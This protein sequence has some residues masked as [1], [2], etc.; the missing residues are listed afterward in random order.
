MKILYIHQ[1]FRLPNQD[2]GHRSYYIAQALQNAGFEVEIIT[3]KNKEDD[4]ENNKNQ[5]KKINV[6]GLTIHYLPIEYHQS[7]GFWGRIKAFRNF[8]WEAYKMALQIHDTKKI[9]LVYATSTPLTVGISAFLL[10]I[11]KKIPYVFEVRDLW[12]DAP[13]ALG[14]LKNFFLVKG[15][16]FLE[17]KIYK[18]AKH[19]I[20]LSPKIQQEIQKKV[21]DNPIPIDMVPNMADN[22]LFFLQKKFD[23]AFNA[24]HSVYPL[25][26]AGKKYH[27]IA[28]MGSVG[29]S[30]HLEYFLDIAE[31]AQHSTEKNIQKLSFWIVGNGSELEKLKKIV[32]DKKLWNIL[33]FK[34]KEKEIL[35]K[36]L[37]HVDFV[38]ISFLKKEILESNSPNKFF[39]ALAMGKC[40]LVNTKG[41]L[42]ELVEQHKC[43]FYAN[44]ETPQSFLDNIK[45]LLE[46]EIL[47]YEM[48]K[49]AKKLAQEQ[50][51]K[52]LLCA[53]VVKICKDLF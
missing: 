19:I 44:P 53:K 29:M 39:D 18:N 51:D 11:R 7:M 8:F 34:S 52:D 14:F 15:A 10:K 12:P 13:I 50:F 36:F 42:Q 9:D 22:G 46:N 5:Y 30:N 6:D 2:G 17:K 41:W 28:Y 27:T 43:G 31:K 45:P 21:T 20:A 47:L 32:H 24:Q 33:F 48:Q 16:K 49:N 37:K 4:K 23:D 3:A 38:Y 35:Q 1:Y 26:N 40:T 25:E